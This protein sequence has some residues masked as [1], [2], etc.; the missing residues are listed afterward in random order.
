MGNI[1]IKFARVVPGVHGTTEVAMKAASNELR[2]L[3]GY[4]LSGHTPAGA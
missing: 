1:F 4:S 2:G 3:R